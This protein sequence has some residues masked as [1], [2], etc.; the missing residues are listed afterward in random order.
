MNGLALTIIV[1]QLPK[2]LGFS[3]DADGLVAEARAFVSGLAQGDANATAA[4]VGVASLAGILL[5][6]RLLPKLPS[7]LIVVVLAAV[8]VN[9]LDLEEHG[10]DTVGVIPQGFPPFTVPA[11]QRGDLPPLLARGVGHRRRSTGGHH[12]HGVRVRGSSRGAGAGEP[13]DGRDRRG[14]HRRRLLPGLPGQHQRVADGGRRAGRVRSQVTGVCWR[15]RHHPGPG[16][17]HRGDGVRPAADVGRDRHRGG[18]VAGRRRR[19][20]STLAATP[21]RSSPCR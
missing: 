1:G 5:L 7:V 19:D 20:A 4:V 18:D 11:C 17:R 15:R 6:N 16:V 8:A 2:L 21:D 3:V 14:E 10:V 12:V 13:G 9:A